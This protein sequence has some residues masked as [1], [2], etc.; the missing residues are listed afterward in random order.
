VF[1]DVFCLKLIVHLNNLS[2]DDE[3]F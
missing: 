1:I 3:Y 2:R